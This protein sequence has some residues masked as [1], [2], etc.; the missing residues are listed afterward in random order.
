[1]WGESYPFSHT[2][3]LTFTACAAS[4]PHD[5]SSSCTGTSTAGFFIKYL[6]CIQTKNQNT[7]NIRIHLYFMY[8]EYPHCFFAVLSSETGKIKNRDSCEV[9]LTSAGKRNCWVCILWD[10]F[11]PVGFFPCDATKPVLLR[12]RFSKEIIFPVYLCK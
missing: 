5:L 6:L 11:V 8:A 7:Q 12:L 3:L 4:K 9:S 10:Y 2:A 1:M